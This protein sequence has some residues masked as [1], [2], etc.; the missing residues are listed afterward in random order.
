MSL[1]A[2]CLHVE[3]AHPGGQRWQ[4]VVKRGVTIPFEGPLSVFDQNTTHYDTLN[5]V[6]QVVFMVHTFGG[7]SNEMNTSRPQVVLKK[8]TDRSASS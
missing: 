5:A 6:G 3:S 8:Q 4:G 1:G 7:G 2:S